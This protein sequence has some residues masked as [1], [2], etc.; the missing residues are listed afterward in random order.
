MTLKHSLLLSSLTGFAF[1][2]TKTNIGKTT[3]SDVFCNTVNV[4]YESTFKFLELDYVQRFDGVLA[5]HWIRKLL[6]Y[7]EKRKEKKQEK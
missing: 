4:D 3:F 1:S 7:S 6:V 2:L 5:C